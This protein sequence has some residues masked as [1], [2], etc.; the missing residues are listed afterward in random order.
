[1]YVKISDPTV[2]DATKRGAQYDLHFYP[3]RAYV[4]GHIVETYNLEDELLDRVL[5]RFGKDGTI[6]IDRMV[7]PIVPDADKPTEPEN[8]PS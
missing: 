8:P 7:N 6:K 1:M 2:L 3:K 5:L 4:S